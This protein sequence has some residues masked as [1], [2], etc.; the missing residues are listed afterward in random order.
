MKTILAVILAVILGAVAGVTTAVVR[1]GA[2]PWGGADE[3]PGP[4]QSPFPAP[5]SLLPRVAVDEE[6]YDFGRMDMHAEGT[7]GFVIENVGDGVLELSGG[8]TSCRCT[9]SELEA[10]EIQPGDSAKVTV[11]WTA[12]NTIGPYRQTAM[13][14]TNDPARPSLT[15]TV[16]GR[17]T[18]A[19]R[20][21]PAE[22][23]LSAVPADRL[24]TAQVRVYCYLD[25]P[26]DILGLELEDRR[27]AEYFQLSLEPL[28]NDRLIEESEAT[29]G[30]LLN[31]TLKPGLPQG[32]FR[33]KILIRTNL[34][35]SPK[36][37]VPIQG[38]ISSDIAIVGRGY[39]RQN[40]VLTF[41]T[42]SS[43]TGAQ[44]R[45]MLFV[46]GAHRKEVKFM[47]VEITPDL[48]RVEL[49]EPKEIR[50]GAV[51]QVPLTVHIPKGSRPANHLG[52]KQGKLGEILLD[53][54]HPQAPRLRILVQFAVTG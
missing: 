8:D 4:T 50:E 43:E 35:A 30:R 19:A 15:L 2:T 11:T 14:F 21:V 9:V 16:S 46:R 20:A 29:S 47:P 48:M 49:G 3:V 28:P 42:V 52:S 6:E 32:P 26:F 17:I 51:T 23:V 45:L 1:T 24:E 38:S 5:G 22:L 54:N 13:V 33:Q 10:T 53:T 7:H 40:G 36:L 18:A 12:E 27:T 41:G 34:E 25:E 44:R 31:V 39:D 37:V